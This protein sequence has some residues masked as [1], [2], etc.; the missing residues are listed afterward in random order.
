MA[1]HS[2]STSFRCEVE[3]LT[4]D[5]ATNTDDDDAESEASDE[6]LQILPTA[7]ESWAGS[8][9]DPTMSEQSSDPDAAPT[10]YMHEADVSD[11]EDDHWACVRCGLL[12]GGEVLFCGRCGTPQAGD[13]ALSEF[14]SQET[15]RE[16][17]P[18]SSSLDLTAAP[19]PTDKVFKFGQH[20]GKSF[21]VITEESPSY[22]FW[23]LTQK[24]PG[25]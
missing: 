17:Q 15:Q 6:G 25:K 23:A 7:E 10:C 9:S 8:I 16:Q 21:S 22:Y 11:V 14:S 20:S 18:S 4:A 5:A 13:G 24:H 1:K 3:V 2:T 12:W 19:T